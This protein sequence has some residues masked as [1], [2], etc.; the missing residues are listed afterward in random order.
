[1][2][3]I[4][5]PSPSHPD[6]CIQIHI[7]MNAPIKMA[8]CFLAF[9]SIHGISLAQGGTEKQTRI[10]FQT[11]YDQGL[12]YKGHVQVREGDY[13]GTYLGLKEDLGMSSWLSPKIT[14]GINFSDKN[15][16]EF[17]YT[18]HFFKGSEFIPNPT[19]YNGTLYAPSSK[20]S[21]DRTIYR[22]FELVWKARIV[23]GAKT[24]LYSRVAVIYE[25]LK[26]YVDAPVAE[27]SPKHETYETFWLQQLPLP[28]IGL[29][30]NHK[31][32][33]K[34]SVN[35]EVSGGYL[36][37]SGTWMNEGGD[38]H[39]EQSN[40]DARLN[41]VYKWKLLSLSTGMWYKHTG[42]TEVSVEDK[43]EFLLN[44]FGYCV[45]LGIGY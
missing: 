13:E 12:S 10:Y 14:A 26:F 36:P 35:T 24:D 23:D 42:I 5:P 11:G 7:P 28:T 4:I 22:G 40:V 27:E 3:L 1:M 34:W 20:A 45:K 43:N 18:R 6:L 38:V 15:I 9:L 39:V 17:T 8:T 25:P 44:G 33:E 37:S 21:I 16:F 32:S 41:V 30:A 19:W 29:Y 31:I 2:T